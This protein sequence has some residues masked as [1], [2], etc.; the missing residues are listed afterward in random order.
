[1]HGNMNIECPH[2]LLAA[3]SVVYLDYDLYTSSVFR[4]VLGL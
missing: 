2:F 1:M 4:G 3:C